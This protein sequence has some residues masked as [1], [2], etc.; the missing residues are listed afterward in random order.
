M[1]RTSTFFTLSISAVSALLAG[2]GGGV[3]PLNQS[4]VQHA[5]ER[6]SSIAYAVLH[7][8]GGSGDGQGPYAGLINVKGTLYGTTRF[9]GANGVGTVFSLTQ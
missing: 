7:S 2:C 1:L 9:G 8:F 3:T 6:R 4:P 5:A